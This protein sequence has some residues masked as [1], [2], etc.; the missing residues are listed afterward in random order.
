MAA[1]NVIP[2]RQAEDLKPAFIEWKADYNVIAS[3]D[4]DVLSIAL[5]QDIAIKFLEKRK[6]DSIPTKIKLE[7]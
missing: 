2:Y 4:D 6:A 3:S 1:D 5:F 7:A